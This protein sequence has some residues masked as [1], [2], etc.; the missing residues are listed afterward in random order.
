[1][2]AYLK[3]AAP[4]LSASPFEG[5]ANGE[6]HFNFYDSDVDQKMF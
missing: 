1:M 6:A 2:V 5:G 3:A 4:K